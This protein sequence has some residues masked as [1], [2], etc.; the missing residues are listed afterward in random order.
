LLWESDADLRH[1]LDDMAALGAEWLRI[2]IPWGAVEPTRGRYYWGPIDRVIDDAA[3]RGFKILAVPGYTPEWNRPPGTSDKF[4]PADL[5]PFGDFVHA[6]AAHYKGRGVRAWEIWNEPNQYFWWGPKP[7]VARYTQLLK[8]AYPAIKSADPSAIVMT[9]GTAP[10]PDMA[11]GSMTSQLAWM[12][13]IYDHGGEGFFDAVAVHPYA[14]PAAPTADPEG[15]FGIQYRLHQLMSLHGDGGKKVW[16]TEFG[17]PTSGHK[18]VSEAMQAAFV[19]DAYTV[20]GTW[21]WAGPLFWFLYRDMG[22]DLTDRVQNM[23][24]AHHDWRPKLAVA[25]FRRIMATRSPR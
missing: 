8:I 9:G 19:T 12:Q 4:G 1:D 10:A 18:A 25:A 2:D 13:Q 5:A 11:D 22:T 23:G 15:Y 16:G 20:I 7:D 17:A 24:I 21:D 6:A 3:A 14:Y